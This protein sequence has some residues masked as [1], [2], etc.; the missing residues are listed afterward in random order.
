M[1]NGGEERRS[2]RHKKLFRLLPDGFSEVNAKSGKFFAR[3]AT[4]LPKVI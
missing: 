1:P 3:P 4:F 2:A